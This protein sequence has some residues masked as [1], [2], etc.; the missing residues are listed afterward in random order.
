MNELTGPL[1]S[2]GSTSSMT[3]PPGIVAKQTVA[4]FDAIRPIDGYGV[5]HRAYWQV[6]RLIDAYPIW[7]ELFADTKEC[8]TR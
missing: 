7:E 1:A 6:E 4:E 2:W 3:V 5:D 8:G